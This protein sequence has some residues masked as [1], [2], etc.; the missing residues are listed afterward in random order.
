[1]NP[2]RYESWKGKTFNQIVSIVKKNKDTQSN[3]SKRSFFRSRPLNIPRRELL[4]AN[5]ASHIHNPR[6]SVSI[7]VINR[8]NGTLVTETQRCSRG[9]ELVLDMNTTTNITNNGSCMIT[10]TC[11]AE[12]AK[13]RL[14]SSGMNR[15]TFNP[16][17]NNTQT[18]YSDNKQYLTSRNK[19]FQQNQYAFV[20]EGEPSVIDQNV[21]SNIY[22]PAGLSPCDKAYITQDGNNNFFSYTWL[23]DEYNMDQDEPDRR[24]PDTEYEV[25]YS[26]GYYNI[27]DFNL[28]LQKVM[29]E[30]GHYVI[31]RNSYVKTFFIKFIY[32]TTRDKIELQCFP[33][34]SDLYPSTVY[35]IPI[36]NNEPAWIAPITST[37]ASVR[38]ITNEIS[39]ITGFNAGYYP[40]ISPW[41]DMIDK[42]V[43]D[44]IPVK[45]ETA[46]A[47]LSESKHHLFPMYTVITYKPSNNRFDNQGAV[48]SSTRILREKYDAITT[49]GSLFAE[50]FGKEVANAMAYGVSEYV[51]T[52][53]DKIGYPLKST[54]VFSKYSDGLV[55]KACS[56][57][58]NMFNG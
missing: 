57:R 12:N 43:L 25:H 39:R 17:K 51:Y 24:I 29:E 37:I 4:S 28:R 40:D 45:R 10:A 13:R 8:P 7:E 22:S 15:K 47:V 44:G 23:D 31:H 26:T 46:Y 18:Y 14:R 41:F 6:T 11:I 36:I 55:A 50:P 38:L 49:N 33:Y 52:K 53:K 56:T 58:K 48:S 2:I 9:L 54:P 42:P 30:N 34:T 16:A 5:D 32:N 21:K 35:S 1:M 20:R 27:D 19:T 3:P